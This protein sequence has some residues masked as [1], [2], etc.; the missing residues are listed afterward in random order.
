[1]WRAGGQGGPAGTGLTRELDIVPDLVMAGALR[2]VDNLHVDWT[3]Q[4]PL[5]ALAPLYIST[6]IFREPGYGLTSLEDQ[7]AIEEL[8][9][10]MG[11]LSRLGRAGGLAHNTEVL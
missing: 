4:G 7:A 1:M 5:G 8:R 3:R 6:T 2:H 11:V 9:L 10:A